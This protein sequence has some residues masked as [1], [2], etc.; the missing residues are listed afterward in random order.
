M[1]R[2]EDE[3]LKWK[4]LDTKHPV[5]NQWLDLREETYQMPDGSVA[6]PFYTFSKKS[7]VVIAA[8]DEDDRFVCVR[9]YRQGIGKV[10]VEFPAGAIETS[11]RH[12]DHETA[13]AAAQRE[14]M[15]ETGCVS[16]HWQFLEEIASM[17]SLNDD[18]AYLYLARGC[19]R[20]G[21][22]KLDVTE[23]LEYET[24]SMEEI[25]AMIMDGSFPQPVH[26]LAYYMAKEV[27]KKSGYSTEDNRGE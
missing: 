6:G 16:E 8:M 14:L 10:T 5:Q 19:R 4:L 15:E 26:A 11:M 21:E 12:P 24:Y 7:Y 1:K 20:V 2:D 17:P 25:R 18:Y 3:K 27:L 13:F 22:Q 23:F 9:Q